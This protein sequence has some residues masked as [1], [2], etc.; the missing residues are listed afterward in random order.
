MSS[1]SI[2]NIRIKRDTDKKIEEA[3][4]AIA[5]ES[6]VQAV[7]IDAVAKRSGVAKTTIYRRYSDR[8][9]L[10]DHVAH[11]IEFA[12]A[13]PDMEP[14][15]ANLV[16]VISHMRA[17]FEERLGLARLGHLLSSE[18]AFL[19]TITD[20]LVKPHRVQLLG[21]FQ[22]GVDERVFRPDVDYTMIVDAIVGAMIVG[23]AH[24]GEVVDQWAGRLV[25]TLW[26]TIDLRSA[27]QVA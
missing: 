26:P 19:R 6:G 2:R 4:L 5:L 14:T 13:L 9:H 24:T 1:R 17:G 15:R 23:A 11:S 8:D 18:S 7:T 21:F 3:T 27:P 20:R 25:A 10:L 12:S 22:R 16:T